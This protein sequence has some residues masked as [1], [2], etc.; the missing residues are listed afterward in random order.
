VTSSSVANGNLA[1]AVFLTTFEEDTSLPL[2][3]LGVCGLVQL[4]KN[5]ALT[6]VIAR[7]K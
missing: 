1:G 7:S 2:V 6:I 3:R 4:P 5:D